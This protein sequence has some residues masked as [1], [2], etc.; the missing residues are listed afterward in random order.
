MLLKRPETFRPDL[1]GCSRP[2]PGLLKRG[3][4]ENRQCRSKDNTF[5]TFQHPQYKL[6]ILL[7]EQAQKERGERLQKD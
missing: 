5:T 2:R 7:R 3:C 4:R 6:K 1:V